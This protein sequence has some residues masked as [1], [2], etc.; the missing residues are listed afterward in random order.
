[1]KAIRLLLCLYMFGLVAVVYGSVIYSL[2]LA[3]DQSDQYLA[4]GAVVFAAMAT[5]VL[6]TVT[7]F[8]RRLR[9]GPTRSV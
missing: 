4:A 3:Y 2:V 8:V 7:L 5:T 9:R 6:V 1:M